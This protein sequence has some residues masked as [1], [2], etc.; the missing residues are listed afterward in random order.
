MRAF[1]CS[2]LLLLVVLSG[3]RGVAAQY[4]DEVLDPY[5]VTGADGALAFE[6][7][8]GDRYGL[9]E[10]I[11]RMKRDSELLWERELP[12]TLHEAH[13]LVSGGVVGLGRTSQPRWAG[14]LIVAVLGADGELRGESRVIQSNSRY[15]DGS[16][17]PSAQDLLVDEFADLAVVRLLDGDS[18]EESWLHV[19][20]STAEK[21]PDTGPPLQPD[22]QWID[23]RRAR[24]VQP[25][26][27][28]EL[29]PWPV[30]QRPWRTDRSV[31]LATPG[32]AT[33]GPFE[34]VSW[35]PLPE[36]GFAAIQRVGRS[37]FDFL[38]LDQNGAESKRASYKLPDPQRDIYRAWF[39][40]A[41]GN[42]FVAGGIGT[43]T[44]P[45]KLWRARDG[46][47]ALEPFPGG[48]IAPSEVIFSLCPL[49]DGGFV[50]RTKNHPIRGRE[51]WLVRVSARG[52]LLWRIPSR[53]PGL[54]EKS[55]DSDLALLPDGSIAVHY[56][57]S[58]HVAAFGLDGAHLWTRA[59]VDEE[60][61]AP[62][63]G[64]SLSVEPDGT[65]LLL[66]HGVG[67]PRTQEETP[68]E[69]W[70]FDAAGTF[71]DK[72][73]VRR[74][75]GATLLPVLGRMQFSPNGTA[76][77]YDGFHFGRLDDDGT[78]ALLPGGSK[79]PVKLETVGALSILED[80]R[81]AALDKENGVLVLWRLDGAWISTHGGPPQSVHGVTVASDGLGNVWLASYSAME[82][83]RGV[84]A[85]GLP[86]HSGIADRTRTSGDVSVRRGILGWDWSTAIEG[87]A[88]RVQQRR[89]DGRWYRNVESLAIRTD[90]GVVALDASGHKFGWPIR[91]L[92]FFAR[93]GDWERTIAIPDRALESGLT[94]RGS[95]IPLH[96]RY[97]AALVDLERGVLEDLVHAPSEPRTFYG[98]G[99]S[100]DGSEVIRVDARARRV[101]WMQ[102]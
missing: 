22:H 84:S 47:G 33:G 88:P 62:S 89:P 3:S 72:V 83:N 37:S 5:I 21:L 44:S 71:T 13:V 50:A 90:G 74:I 41:D 38:L 81:I 82:P 11:H 80:G 98:Y 2:L 70:R 69:L 48:A 53:A 95:R 51:G 76:W 59:L 96:S 8:P 18:R 63:N 85:A 12:F 42:W 52:E 34:L 26:R 45:S 75:D 61:A 6:V 55:Y 60:G 66:N 9:R 25:L 92:H 31:E 7:V 1:L 16:A 87:G 27:P 24:D 49:A 4:P 35:S 32:A 15:K 67:S 77:F 94:V 91:E 19:R 100:P 10:G 20:L 29:E 14:E 97:S 40:G 30:E 54:G 99:L 28:A 57:G 93:G 65:M 43:D 23:V 56:T 17:N 64:R 78:I 101:E 73:S 86:L 39:R 68:P 36:G 79:Q 58:S 46:G 102:L